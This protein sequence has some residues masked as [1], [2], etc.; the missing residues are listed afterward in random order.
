MTTNIW[1]S[2]PS[3][4]GQL[5]RRSFYLYRISFRQVLFITILLGVTAFLPRFMGNF[6]GEDLIVSSSWWDP[7]RIWLIAVDL[8]AIVLFVAMLW[9]INGMIREKHEPLSEDFTQGAKKAVSVFV[10]AFIQALILFALVIVLFSFITVLYRYQL[11]FSQDFWGILFTLVIIGGQA[12]LIF[13]VA[14]LFLFVMPIIAVE[15]KGVLHAIEKSISLVWNHWWLTISV[16]MTPWLCYA[17]VMIAIKYLLHIDVHIYFIYDDSRHLGSSF[18]Q[19]A[20]FIIFI[21]WVASLLLVQ[22]KD[23]ELRKSIRQAEHA[24]KISL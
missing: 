18:L 19:L 3:T 20:M 5:I 6:T 10:A 9:R 12:L 15:N 17:L 1:P 21:P 7:R 23:L 14:T 13:Y 16:Q 22:L 24:K 4:Y 2:H 8:V 11:L